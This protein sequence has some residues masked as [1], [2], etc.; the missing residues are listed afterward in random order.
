MKIYNLENIVFK[1]L[2]VN[3]QC[4][5]DDHMLYIEV[6][7]DINPDA[8]RNFRDAFMHK[9]K[10]DLPPFESVSRCRRKL[11]QEYPE[12]KVTRVAKARDKKELDYMEY[13]V[14]NKN[15]DV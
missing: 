10:Y 3:K 7:S 13:A 14:E 1:N 8:V 2:V 9:D 6:A 15:I 11:Q 12:L 5:V 4:R